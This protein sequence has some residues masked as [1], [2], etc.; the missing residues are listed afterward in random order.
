MQ[1]KPKDCVIWRRM[2]DVCEKMGKTKEAVDY[3]KRAVDLAP[4]KPKNL[5]LLI[6]S[7]IVDGDRYL[8]QS[9]LRQLEEVNPENQK[10]KEYQPQIEEL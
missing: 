5:S 6:E 1:I 10:L 9:T 4:K 2:G 8:A 7:R 3:Y